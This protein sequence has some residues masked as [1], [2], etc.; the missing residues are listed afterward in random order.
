MVLKKE[1][2]MKDAGVEGATL[3]DSLAR[4]ILGVKDQRLLKR[5]IQ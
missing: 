5:E 1:V 2:V 3:C 4:R